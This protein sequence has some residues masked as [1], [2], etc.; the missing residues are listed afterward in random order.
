M[1][2]ARRSLYRAARTL[3][4]VEAVSNGRVAERIV[5]KG[6]GR[7]YGSLT[8]GGCLLPILAAAVAILYAV[9]AAFAFGPVRTVVASLWNWL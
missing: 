7:A 3:G 8:N 2:K 9:G 5:N 6:M 4:D 1:S